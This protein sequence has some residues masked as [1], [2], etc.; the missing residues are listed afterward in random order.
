[1]ELK[2]RRDFRDL[3]PPLTGDEYEALESSIVSDG[4]R[5][6]LVVWGDTILD[7]HN[8]YEICK[9]HGIAFNVC[10]KEFTDDEDAKDWMD[11]NQ[12]G[13][14]NLNPDQR[15]IIIGRRYNREKK[16]Q[17]APEGNQNRTKQSDQ[18]DHFKTADSIGKDAGISSPT[19]RRYAKDAELFDQIKESQPEVAKDVWSGQKTLKDIKSEQ[20]KKEARE[21]NK[22]IQKI[23]AALKEDKKYRVIYADPPWKYND[24]CVTG[25]VQ[26]G[27]VEINHYPT[28]S[29]Q[30][31]CDMPIKNITEKDAVLF[32]R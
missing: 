1:M 26:G 32:L 25:G 18:N 27:G 20:K 29:I 23:N 11:K 24:Q 8:R 2:I 31:I 14:R 5:D 12:L 7:G 15:R 6:A 10:K 22:A 4:C 30:E 17:G 13:R 3:I 9:K 16:K 19:V 21:R 28:M